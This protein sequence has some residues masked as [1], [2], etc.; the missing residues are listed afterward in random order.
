MSLETI[1]ARRSFSEVCQEKANRPASQ[2]E[3]GDRKRKYLEFRQGESE[4]VEE[5]QEN[6]RHQFKPNFLKFRGC[7][8]HGSGSLSF[9]KFIMQLDREEIVELQYGDV[10]EKLGGIFGWKVCD[11]KE[12]EWAERRKQWFMQGKEGKVYKPNSMFQILRRLGYFPT[13]NTRRA[14]HGLDFENSRTFQWD[15]R[16]QTKY[17]QKK[18]EESKNEVS[19]SSDNDEGRGSRGVKREKM[20][21]LSA[22]KVERN[23]HFSDV[24]SL[25]TAN[26]SLLQSLINSRSEILLR[27]IQQQQLLALVSSHVPD[28]PLSPQTPP[29]PPFTGP[30]LPLLNPLLV[31]RSE[32]SDLGALKSKM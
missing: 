32:M 21:D 16:R 18:E 5:D 11:G 6:S 12:K 15:G 4:S 28:L 13:E 3:Q 10:P 2:E 29:S 14:S 26:I 20:D 25:E 7:K 19:N 17:L 30:T 9:L 8:Q 24:E 23:V 31:F 22:V 27:I 1:L